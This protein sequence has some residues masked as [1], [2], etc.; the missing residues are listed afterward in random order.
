[1][2]ELDSYYKYLIESQK[3]EKGTIEGQ[4]EEQTVSQIFYTANSRYTRTVTFGL[5]NRLRSTLC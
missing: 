2:L 5:L 1:M 3:A 4:T